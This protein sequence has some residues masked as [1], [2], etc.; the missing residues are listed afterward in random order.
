VTAM[1]LL[2]VRRCRQ[3]FTLME[4]LLVL[5]LLV[6]M[7]SLAW[8]ALEKGFATQRL[9]KAADFVQ[10]EW[11]RARVKAMS[12][13]QIHIF[14]YSMGGNRYATHRR[15]TSEVTDSASSASAPPGFGQVG[16]ETPEPFGSERE[17]PKDVGFAGSE[18]ASGTR[19]AMVLADQGQFRPADQ[20]WSQPIFFY[21]DGTTSTARLVLQNKQG[22][23]IQ[24]A[25]RGLTGVVTVGDVQA[26]EERLP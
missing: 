9:R 13:G 23:T 17:L 22:R 19:E 21:P 7:A 3:A 24:L 25:L 26:S 6:A 20:G 8:P 4:V 2:P 5:C 11:A 16:L 1:G 14:Q 10:A 15:I 12:T 18:A